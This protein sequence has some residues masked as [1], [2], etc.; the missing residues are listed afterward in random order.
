MASIAS[1]SPH[2]GQH[3][4]GGDESPSS[5]NAEHSPLPALGSRIRASSSPYSNEKWPALS[6]WAES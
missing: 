3:E 4:P 6:I 2:C 1:I 5:Q